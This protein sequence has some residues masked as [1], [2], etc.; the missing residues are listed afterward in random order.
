MVFHTFLWNCLL[1][2]H[3]TQCSQYLDLPCLIVED[4]KISSNH[5]LVVTRHPG[6]ILPPTETT[7]NDCIEVTLID[8]GCSHIV[9]YI[10][11]SYDT[12]QPEI[13]P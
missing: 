5:N 2:I 3:S 7:T 4:I 10:L 6:H 13:S 12:N 1:I 9:L 8:I 11:A